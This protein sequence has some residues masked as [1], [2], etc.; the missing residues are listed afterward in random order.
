MTAATT[1]LDRTEARK[2]V[3][4]DARRENREIRKRMARRMRRIEKREMRDEYN[5]QEGQD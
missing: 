2:R 1:V 4:D 3:A 5:I